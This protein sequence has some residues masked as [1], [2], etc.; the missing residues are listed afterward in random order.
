[1]AK[2]LHEHLFLADDFT[3]KLPYTSL[4]IGGPLVKARSGI[5]KE[6]HGNFV[7]TRFEEAI[8]D[9]REGRDETDFVYLVFKSAL[10]FELDINKFDDKNSFRIASVKVLQT[11]DEEGQTINYYETAVFLARDSINTFLK[12][13][14][15]YLTQFTPKS[16]GTKPK[17]LT[18]IAN[19]DDIRAATL[20]S[21][22]QEPEI[23]FPN[24]N[25]SIWWEV[26]LDRNE[27]EQDN[28]T[29]LNLLKSEGLQIGS[30][31]LK[32][33]EHSVGLIKGSAKLLGK[34]LLYT[35]KLAELRKPRETAD[36]FTYL[37]RTEQNEWLNDLVSRVEKYTDGSS[38]SVCLLDSGVNIGNPALSNLVP[39]ENLD[40]VIP[41]VGVADTSTLSTGHGTPMAGLILYGDL[42]D[43]LES[44]EN[45]R[46]YHHLE[47]VKLISEQH[48]HD[49]LNYGYITKEA[50]AR[51]E[52]INP[53]NKRIVCLSVTEDNPS[54][55]GTPT[56]WSATIDQ[57]SFG[58]VKDHN[59]NTLFLVSSGNMLDEERVNYPL[60]NNDCSINSPAQ[61]FNAITVG[62]YT[63]K[64]LI[65][66]ERHPESELL[67]KRGA[68]SPC[69]TTSISWEKS[70]CRKPDLVMEGGNQALQYEG[71]LTPDSLQLLSTAKGNTLNWLAAFGDTSGSTALASRFAASLYYRYP[72]LWPETI[73]GLMI[74]SA[75]WTPQMLKAFGT[76][77]T[78]LNHL[79]SE[80][81]QKLLQTVGYGVPQQ[82]RAIYSA[83]DSLTLIAERI[84]KPFKLEDSRIKTEEFHLFE[85]P[86]PKEELGRLFSA[87]VQLKITLSYFIE[88]NPGNKRYAN[89]NNY[90]SHGLR[91]KMIDS[92]ETLPAFKGRISKAT[93]EE[94]YE[95]EGGERNWLL[96]DKIRNKGAVHKD[97]W[98]GTATELASRNVL[99]VYPVGGWWKSRKKLKRYENSVRY[100]IIISIETPVVDVDIYTP[101][102]NQI[103]ISI[104]VKL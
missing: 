97:I 49:P 13:I 11:T 50:V 3:S 103:K 18:L 90:A 48:P 24:T 72:Y 60:S 88:P 25:E 100:S 2:Q 99:A 73:R 104:P 80:E 29:L 78:H 58:T 32:F 39:K 46:I 64:D 76:D 34:T 17:N 57:L 42:T 23:P 43:V 63:L 38:I 91:F 75:D 15:Q 74:H 69:N 36:F 20:H 56:A 92:N 79:A 54:H 96:G 26:W 31:W 71:L 14:E 6:K 16:K 1:M 93:Q 52:I 66:F 98:E 82:E 28:T 5:N 67:A 55:R 53:A 9:F 40:S 27:K 30:Q 19:I 77:K 59:N 70:W 84:L 47:S 87:P 44:K 102:L 12:K 37:Y 21:F 101:V 89:A 83:N 7:K 95:K 85:L 10:S 35:D 22:W 45:I 94:L 4:S 81:K 65:D 61:A 41:E 68:M 86:W 8:S 51:A 33:P 62:A